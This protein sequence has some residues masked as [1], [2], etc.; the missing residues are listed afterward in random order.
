MELIGEIIAELIFEG[1]VAVAKGK[2]PL[3]LK[4]TAIVLIALICIAI[5]GLIAFV[6]ISCISDGNFIGGAVILIV[7][8]LM[9]ILF[10]KTRKK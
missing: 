4:I 1:L 7:E 9:I 5:V 2:Y 6:G 8:I 10:L 3:G